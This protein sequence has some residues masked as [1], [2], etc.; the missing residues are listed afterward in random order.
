M[1]APRVT[2]VDYGVGNLFSV[3]RAFESVGANVEFTSDAAV[4]ESAERLV[5]PGVGAFADGMLGLSERDLVPALRRFGQS[6]RPFLGICLGMQMLASVSEE[7]GEHAGLDLIPGRVVPLQP[8]A[9]DGA[10]LKVPR[11]G[12]SP[13]L[14]SSENAWNG[15]PL[16]STPEGTSV[17]LVHSFEVRTDEP[18]SAIASCPYGGR[19]I[20]TVIRSGTV[21]GCQFH[22]EKSGPAGLRMLQQFTSL[23]AP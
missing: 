3:Q 11:V 18:S 20:T 4:I 5:L 9:V 23:R 16:E 2:V 1:S 15:T 10:R 14:A 6:G 22:P 7:F 21:F 12:W 13:L 8:V 17:Y 19:A